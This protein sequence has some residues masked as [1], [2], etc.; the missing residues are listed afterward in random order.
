MEKKKGVILG[1]GDRSYWY[2][3]YALD[4]SDEFEIIGVIDPDKE[5]LDKAKQRFGLSDSALYT[6]LDEFLDKKIDCDVVINGTMDKL[7]YVTTMKLL[8]NNY[9]VLLEKPITSVP[10]E[11]LEI[12]SLAKEAKMPI[13]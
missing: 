1:Y 11:L 9:N 3:Q 4:C 13:I 5:K 6:D 8:K 2:S 7:H 10:E 12:E